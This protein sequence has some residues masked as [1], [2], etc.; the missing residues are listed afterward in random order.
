NLDSYHSTANL[1][2][3]GCSISLDTSHPFTKRK[4]FHI[5]LAK[6]PPCLQ[7]SSSN[8]RSLP[9]GELNNIPT[10]TPSAPYFLIKSNGSGEF[11]SCLDI[12]LR[13]L[14]LTIPVRYTFLKGLSPLYSYPAIIIL[15][16]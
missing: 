2:A 16:T 14:S 15:A 12:F 7:R 1:A 13:S 5:L 11:P 10:L 4:A 6:A 3:S 9:A 8:I